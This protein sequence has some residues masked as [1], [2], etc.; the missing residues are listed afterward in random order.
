MG[1]HPRHATLEACC[2]TIVSA[3]AIEA[4]VQ[5]AGRRVNP[6]TCVPTA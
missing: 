2:A 5:S 1:P 3:G 6:G 4:A